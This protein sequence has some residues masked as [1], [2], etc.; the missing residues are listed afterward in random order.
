MQQVIFCA[1]FFKLLQNQ[2]SDEKKIIIK[3]KIKNKLNTILV[4]KLVLSEILHL[5]TVNKEAIRTFGQRSG[6]SRG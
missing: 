4:T 2:N 3:E 6:N 1:I 5:L